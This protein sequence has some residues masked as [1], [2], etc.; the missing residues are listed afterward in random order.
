MCREDVNNMKKWILLFLVI[1]GNCLIFSDEVN[2]DKLYST[3]LRIENNNYDTAIG[4][5]THSKGELKAFI[6]GKAALEN[7]RDKIYKNIS[8]TANKVTLIYFDSKDNSAIKEVV[9]LLKKKKFRGQVEII[10]F[11]YNESKS[12]RNMLEKNGWTYSVYNNINDI[13][14][15]V[16]YNGTEKPKSE[17]IKIFL[18]KIKRT[19]ENNKIVVY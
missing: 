9:K 8:K 13:S 10:T 2:N 16:M 15:M 3:V 19:L 11:F 17:V 6:M 18:E 5:P 14:E 4:I 12:L 7:D 1:F